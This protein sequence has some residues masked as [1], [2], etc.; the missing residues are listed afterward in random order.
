MN[1]MSAEIHT[2]TFGSHSKPKKVTTG[3]IFQISG[4]PG[5]RTEG[6]VTRQIVEG[7]EQ[8]VLSERRRLFGGL[9][10]SGRGERVIGKGL[11]ITSPV[12]RLSGRQIEVKEAKKVNTA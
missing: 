12:Q 3:E 9:L 6:Y 5:F 1:T 11:D 7:E 4:V 10:L 8:L 2:S